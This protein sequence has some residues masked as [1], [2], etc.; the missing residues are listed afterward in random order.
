[1]KEQ[2]TKHNGTPEQT[3]PTRQ[4]EQIRR[5]NPRL[6]IGGLDFFELIMEQEET[7]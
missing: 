7:K 5:N 1:M 3:E 6:V 2:E 4:P